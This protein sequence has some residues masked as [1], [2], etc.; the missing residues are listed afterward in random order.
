MSK[1]T[2]LG[3][4]LLDHPRMP[5]GEDTIHTMR[6]RARKAG[7]P[8]PYPFIISRGRGRD[9]LVDLDAARA[10]ADAEGMSHVFEGGRVR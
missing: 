6:W 5:V 3:R 10:W 7:K 4:F 9:A 1:L 8:L 2:T